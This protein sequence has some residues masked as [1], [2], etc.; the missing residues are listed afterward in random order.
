MIWDPQKTIVY[1]YIG[2]VEGFEYIDS[3][4]G[5]WFAE[6]YHHEKWVYGTGEVEGNQK[7]G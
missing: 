7:W 4:L 5:S 2:Q 1:I 6:I 3:N